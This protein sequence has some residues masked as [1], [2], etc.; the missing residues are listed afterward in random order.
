MKKFL[1]IFLTAVTILSM[2]TMCVSAAAPSKDGQLGYIDYLDFSAKNNVWAER[3]EEDVLDDKGEVVHKKGDLVHTSY[4]ESDYVNGAYPTA[5]FLPD[6][7]DYEDRLSY[8]FKE[9]GEVAVFTSNTTGSA[10][11]SFK[12]ASTGNTFTAGA[13]ASGQIEYV[14]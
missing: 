1:A 7:Y 13:E 9:N 2:A 3:Y 8:T 12:I 11:L 10:G 6:K 14:K 5:L 4:G